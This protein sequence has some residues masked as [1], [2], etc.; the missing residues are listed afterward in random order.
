[1]TSGL[2]KNM[3][4]VDQGK[5]ITH[6]EKRRNT[7]HGEDQMERARFKGLGPKRIPSMKGSKERKRGPSICKED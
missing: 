6:W 4:K 3:P 7:A 2:R 5:R 1:M